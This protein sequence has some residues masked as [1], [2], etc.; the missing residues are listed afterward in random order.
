MNLGSASEEKDLNK[1]LDEVRDFAGD[2][3][4][5][6]GRFPPFGVIVSADG[7]SGIAWLQ[8]DLVFLE[9]S[10]SIASRRPFR[11]MQHKRTC[12]RLESLTWCRWKSN[13]SL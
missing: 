1:L 6:T 11:Q 7:Q 13:R 2:L 9:R 4:G 8:P 5:K 3:I 10:S 12:A